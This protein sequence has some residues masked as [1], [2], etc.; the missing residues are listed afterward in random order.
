[1]SMDQQGPQ[2]GTA[3]SKAEVGSIREL[4]SERKA[5][6]R[7]D[8]RRQG[9]VQRPAQLQPFPPST[10]PKDPRT[11]TRPVTTRSGS[12]SIRASTAE[13]PTNPAVTVTPATPRIE[14]GGHGN[15]A[16][17]QAFFELPGSPHTS[18]II[19]ERRK[20]TGTPGIE[21]VEVQ[22]ESPAA[23]TPSA[24][25]VFERLSSIRWG[26]TAALRIEEPVTF[27]GEAE[28]RFRNF[29][30]TLRT[31]TAD[32]A[33]PDRDPLQHIEG[34]WCGIDRITIQGLGSNAKKQNYIRF[35]GVENEEDVK[36]LHA[37][38]SKKKFRKEY[39]PLHI[40]YSLQGITPCASGTKLLRRATSSLFT[41]YRPA[42]IDSM[43]SALV[44]HNPSEKPRLHSLCGTLMSI[45]T[46]SN[47]RTVTI[48]GL[49]ALNDTLFAITA[50]HQALGQRPPGKSN[51]FSIQ[52]REY[53]IDIESALV[54]RETEGRSNP[55]GA[56]GDEP[57][58][59]SQVRASGNINSEVTGSDWSLIPVQIPQK[60][61]PNLVHIKRDDDHGSSI[62]VPV[63]MTDVSTTPRKCI[64][65][66]LGGVSGLRKLTM[67]PTTSYLRT[68]AGVLVRAWKAT[69][70]S[71]NPRGYQF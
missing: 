35:K 42:S 56:R 7:A 50:G 8:A 4:A 57:P 9:F 45:G 6:R 63:H 27:R 3:N 24:D 64:V 71:N 47:R 54:F 17:R 58:A 20:S 22:R 21:P 38:L 52:E 12:T 60:M 2:L 44:D 33:R 29:I 19:R 51:R 37:V 1:M 14:S 40:C 16:A 23:G 61:L 36:V 43:K 62:V 46:G 10:T 53:D 25:T 5:A 48:G 39:H 18:A 30:N 66:V 26:S 15:V 67:K 65:H 59:P 41:F 34:C 32:R 68:A 11:S 31:V 55:Q 69:Y 70:G 28:A 13:P 49:I